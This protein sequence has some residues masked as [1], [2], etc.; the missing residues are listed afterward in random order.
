MLIPETERALLLIGGWHE[1]VVYWLRS[2]CGAE[3]L[4]FGSGTERS[5]FARIRVP[6]WK[7]R[8]A[9]VV[10]G[11]LCHSRWKRGPDLRDLANHGFSGS[12]RLEETERPWR[13]F[14]RRR[15]DSH[16]RPR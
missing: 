12:A 9:A 11:R 15:Q 7:L 14:G 2:R 5:K 6:A 4:C 8:E 1:A 3:L 13:Y 10:V 16:G